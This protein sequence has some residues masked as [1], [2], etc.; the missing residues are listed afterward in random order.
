MSTKTTFKR[1]ALVA[2]AS[3]GLGVLTSVTPANAAGSATV[4]SIYVSK[5]SV[6]SG[7]A[8]RTAS[9][10]SLTNSSTVTLVAGTNSNFV[11]GD[12]GKGLFSLDKGYLGTIAAYTQAAGGA[13]GSVTLNANSAIAVTAATDVY[14]GTVAATKTASTIINADGIN[15]MTATAGSAAAIL[16]R[17]STAEGTS[18]TAKTRAVIDNA[19]QVGLSSAIGTASLTNSFVP[20]TVPSQVG[21]YSMTVGYSSDA[22]FDANV[23]KQLEVKFTL[24]VTAAADLSLGASTAFMTEPSANGS[25]ASST[26][27][28]IARSASKAANTGIAQIL[29]TLLKSDG[30]ADTSAHT[31]TADVSGVGY[32]SVNQTANTPGT[33]TTRSATTAA[34]ASVNYVHI[35]SDGTAG[36]GTVTVSVTHAVTGVKSVLGTFSYTS[37]GDVSKIE[38]SKKNFTIGKAGST[39]GAAVTA[40][41]Q[42][43]EVTNKGALTAGT[44][45]PAFIVKA[46]DS[47][48]NVASI[49]AA[50][51]TVP[52]VTSSDA[53]VISSGT[54]AKDDG[55]STTYSSGSGNGYYNCSFTAASSAKSGSKAT[56]TIKTVNPA[57]TATYLT[58]TLDVTVGGTV[59]KEK[60]SFDKSS[61]APGEGMIVTRTATDASGNPVAD[62]TAS[63]AISFTKSVGGTSPA[64]GFYVGGKSNSSDGTDP[65]TV[66]A[67]SVSGTFSALATG[68]DTAATALS[69]EATVAGSNDALLNSLIKKINDLSKLVAKIQKK[70]GV[71]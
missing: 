9:L 15:A 20:F 8:S 17:L 32:V 61:Y 21:T 71:K 42:T 7:W 13:A 18:T 4:G 27:N 59:S 26:T 49:S 51:T 64:A 43:G 35:N 48:G 47:A 46:T 54:C 24:T 36:T 68:T 14:V 50:N 37:Y 23:T 56:L 69:A 1:I 25:T 30:T 5:Y 12:I 29:V 57:D 52:T 65:K 41:T 66:F 33:P 6:E 60:L 10:T 70:L 22:S 39:T 34:G 2:V 67:P 55:S 40:R 16:V 62:G 44:T 45:T 63:P 38:V 11:A 58:T 31:I 28:A 19:G 53:T 3:L